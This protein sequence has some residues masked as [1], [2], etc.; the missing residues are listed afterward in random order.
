VAKR[1]SGHIYGSIRGGGHGSLRRGAA[2]GAVES[3][4][5]DAAAFTD[6]LILLFRNDP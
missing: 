2:F 5:L 6:C 3:R 1:G 4:R